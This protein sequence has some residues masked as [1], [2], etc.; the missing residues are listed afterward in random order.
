MINRKRGRRLLQPFGLLKRMYTAH[1]KF[2][3]NGDAD[4]MDVR[5]V[6]ARNV[7]QIPIS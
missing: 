4:G 2:L 1:I 7:E 3:T 6:S 5:A